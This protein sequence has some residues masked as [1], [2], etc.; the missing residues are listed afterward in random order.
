MTGKSAK[1]PTP[2]RA[3]RL[4]IVGVGNCASALLQGIAAY[5]GVAPELQWGAMHPILG[6]YQ[7]TDI[8]PVA[9]FDVDNRKVGLDLAEAIFAPPN[10]A[11]RL[12]GVSVP[13]TG[14]TV[15]MGPVLDGVPEHLRQSIEV[16]SVRPVDVVGV[17]RETGTHVLVNCLPTG[18]AQAARWYAEAALKAGAAF[19]N[20]MPELIACDQEFT[21]RARRSNI[22]VI[23]DDVKS[24]LGATILHRAIIRVMVD[25]GIRIRKTYQLNY[26]G[27]TDFLNL[28]HRGESKELT[29][30]EALTTLI[31]YDAEVSPGFAYI[32][33][34]GDRKTARF[35]FEAEN[36]GGAPLVI[37]AK[38][39]VED[40]AN[41][42]G[43]V[44]DAIRCCKI[45][46]DRGIGGVLIAASAYLMKHPPEPMPDELAREA[47]EEFIAGSR[48]R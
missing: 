26:A 20:G 41:F 38:L 29:K 44:A 12:P 16:A 14:V 10:C 3:I 15:Q 31:P 19:V 28:V 18:S 48:E 36:F 32:A 11:Y 25:R 7:V 42:A 23:G 5:R 45:A 8:Q 13:A 9:A 39:E 2:H 43:V 6:G 37:D 40:S 22:P 46:L 34:M 33:N 47:L 27:N 4:G 35:Y 30:V 17:L 21:E 24:Q 1:S